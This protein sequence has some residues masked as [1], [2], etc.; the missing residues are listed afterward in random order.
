[1][2]ITMTEAY[3]SRSVSGDSGV[4]TYIIRGTT[5]DTAAYGQLV[6]GAPSSM[7]LTTG[8]VLTLNRKQSSVRELAGDTADADTGIWRGRAVYSRP[9]VAEETEAGNLSRKSFD[10]ALET[11][12]VYNSRQT[13]NSYAASG[14]PADF[15]GLINVTKQGEQLAAGG[16]DIPHGVFTWEEEHIF[17]AASVTNSYINGLINLVD[18]T[19]VNNDTFRD[20]PA[21]SVRYL[22]TSGTTRDD[23]DWAL[24]FRFA[25]SKN[26]TGLEV[27]DIT[28]ITKD[29]WDY[30]WTFNEETVD[31]NGLLIVKPKFAYVERVHKRGDFSVFGI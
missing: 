5:S 29:G 11:I 12:R 14:T 19:P 26:V 24:T 18:D 7:V 28:G 9:E 20:A 30:L 16:V 6:G 3:Q 21:G 4:R 1:M 15:G 25:G 31:P 27:G 17:S 23:G 13:V 10:I 8:T 2:A 22:G